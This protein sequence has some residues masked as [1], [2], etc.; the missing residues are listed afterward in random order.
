MLNAVIGRSDCNFVLLS[1]SKSM[2]PFVCVFCC[3]FFFL[4]LNNCSIDMSLTL[5]MYVL[6]IAHFFF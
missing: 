2:E 3:F 6:R 1:P 4:S 5:D